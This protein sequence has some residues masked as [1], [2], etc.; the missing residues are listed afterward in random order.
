MTTTMPAA[1]RSPSRAAR[2]H[3]LTL[4]TGALAVGLS[5]VALTDTPSLPTPPAP[6]VQ[7]VAGMDPASGS[8]A[9]T[10]DRRDAVDAF[11]KTAPTF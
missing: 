7:A 10:A 9:R 6:A 8:T 5:L 4:A 1:D 11:E 3:W 2:A